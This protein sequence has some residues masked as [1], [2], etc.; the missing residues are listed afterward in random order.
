MYL[1]VCL[2]KNK[3][4]WP[5]DMDFIIGNRR[6][7]LQNLMSQNGGRGVNREGGLL[8]KND[9]Q[10]GGLLESGRGLNRAFL[11]S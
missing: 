3:A 4:T 6:D 10:T 9:F 7:Q 8:L 5:H 2:F 11:F 1:C